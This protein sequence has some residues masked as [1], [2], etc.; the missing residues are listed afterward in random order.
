VQDVLGEHQDA[1]VAC[2]EINRLVAERPHDGPFNLAAGRLLERQEQAAGAA[3]SQF[4]EVWA[5]LDRKK[6]VRWLK[7]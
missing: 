1:I 2:Q 5:K 7:G 6:N 4:F 3:R